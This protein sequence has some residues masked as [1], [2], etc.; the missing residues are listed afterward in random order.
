MFALFFARSVCFEGQVVTLKA[1]PINYS[2][3]V[4]NVALNHFDNVKVIHTALG[5]AP[6]QLTLMFSAVE[7]GSRS[8]HTEV[9]QQFH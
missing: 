7:A 4:E 2:R 6:G 9:Q 1:N 3:V 5:D 8:L